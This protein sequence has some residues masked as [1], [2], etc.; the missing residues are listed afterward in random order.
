MHGIV[1]QVLLQIPYVEL[2]RNLHRLSFRTH[3][4]P[5]CEVLFFMRRRN[6]LIIGGLATI[7]LVIAAVIIVLRFTLPPPAASIDNVVWSL[8]YLQVNGQTYTLVPNVPVT[9]TF[10]ES[11][12]TITGNSGCNS[13][14]ATYQRQDAQVR[15][16]DFAVT[17]MGCLGPEGEQENL[18]LQALSRAETL[19]VAGNGMTITGASGKDLLRFSSS[20]TAQGSDTNWSNSGNWSSSMRLFPLTA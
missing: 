5:V 16:Q 9:L 15:F 18:Y 13:Y 3:G 11:S 17:A 20:W 10:D 8:T 14:Q 19:H 2:S 1:Y 12:H 4:K 6:L 7:G